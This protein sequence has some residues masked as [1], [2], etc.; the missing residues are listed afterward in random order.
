MSQEEFRVGRATT[1]RR[2]DRIFVDLRIQQQAILT[3][4]GRGQSVEQMPP[5][6]AL[7]DSIRGGEQPRYRCLS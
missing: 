7:V 1:L 6:D 5:F 4:E 3:P 2:P